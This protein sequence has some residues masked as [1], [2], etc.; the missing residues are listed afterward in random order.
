[1]QFPLVPLASSHAGNMYAGTGEI[2]VIA[3]TG[4][5]LD[6]TGTGEILDETGTGEIL[7]MER[8]NYGTVQEL[9]NT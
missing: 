9:W 2:L 3:G 6:A 7:D 4:N 1:M 8:G 5:T